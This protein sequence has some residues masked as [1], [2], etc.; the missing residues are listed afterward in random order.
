[1]RLVRKQLLQSSLDFNF[2]GFN[3]DKV[4]FDKAL[5]QFKGFEPA[6]EAA[7]RDWKQVLSSYEIN[8]GKTISI[9]SSALFY[10]FVMKIIG[11]WSCNWGTIHF[12]MKYLIT[13][14]LNDLKS[15]NKIRQAAF[16]LQFFISLMLSSCNNI[17]IL[18]VENIIHVSR[19]GKNFRT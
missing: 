3:G 9:F 12:T 16:A 15:V 10:H 2:V 13:E 18:A 4:K 17:V 19:D 1:M 11:S 6:I 7:K 5:Q 8:L 14:Y